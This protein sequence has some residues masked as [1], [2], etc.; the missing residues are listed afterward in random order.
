MMNVSNKNSSND[1]EREDVSGYHCRMVE[2]KKHRC[3]TCSVS[4]FD[5]EYFDFCDCVL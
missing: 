2:K 5:Y 1:K 4:F 3:Q